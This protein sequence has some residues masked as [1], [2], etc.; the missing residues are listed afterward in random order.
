MEL[1]AVVLG[2]FVIGLIARYSL[3][4]RDLMGALLIPAVTTAIA[5]IVWEILLWARLSPGQPWIWIITLVLAC[6]TAFGGSLYL[7]RRRAQEDSETL[8]SALKG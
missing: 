8:S 2:A 6:A 4:Q 5:A 1:L 3:P 7:I